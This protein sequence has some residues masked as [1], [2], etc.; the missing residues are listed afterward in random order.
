MKFV[1]ALL[2]RSRTTLSLLAI[3]VFT[4][5]YSYK[6]MPV[7]VTPNIAT[8][9]ISILIVLD[10]VSPEDGVRL[11]IRPSENQLRNIDGVKE[12]TARALE[13]YVNLVL[14]FDSSVDPAVA[15]N[16]VRAAMQRVRGDLPD[17]AK[18]PVVRELTSAEFPTVVVSL[19]GENV[20]ERTLYSTAQY[21][22]RRIEALPNVLEARLV[23]HRE[24]VVEAIINREQLETYK[25]TSGELLQAVSSNNVLIPAGELDT[26]KG[27]FSIKLPGLIETYQDVFNLPI[28]ATTEGVVKLGDLAQ[29][30]RTFKDSH[31]ITR[32]DGQPAISIEVNQRNGANMIEVANSVRQ[33]IQ[34]ESA[35][36]PAGVNAVF[37]FDQTPFALGMV[38]ELEGNIIAALLLVMVVIVAALG[39]RSGILVSIGVP[40]SMLIAM[41]VLD[42][43]DYSFN[44]M[45]LFGFLLSLGMVVDGAIVITEYADCRMADGCSSREAYAASVSR[46]FW[47]AAASIATTLGAF[48][49]LMFWQGTDG[50]FMRILPTTVFATLA[51][52]LLFALVFGPVLGGIF[53]KSTMDPETIHYLRVLEHEDPRQL[54]GVT[55]AYARMIERVH[56][57]PLLSVGISILGIVTIVMLY[58]KFNA[59]SMHFT[60]SEHN[61]GTVDVSARGNLSAEESAALVLEVEKIVRDTKNVKSVYTAAY[62]VGTAQGRR[63]AAEDEIGHMLV[64]LVDSEIRGVSSDEIFWDIRERTKH[65]PGIRVRAEGLKGGPPEGKDIQLQMTSDNLQK[66]HETAR[67]VRA[68]VD[69]MSQLIDVDDTLPLPGVEW[70][71]Q[72]DRTQAA[73]YGASVI[74]AGL[75]VQ[76]ITDGVK[77][78]EYR[79]D[80]AEE[81][82]EIRVRYPLPERSVEA[83]DMLTVN[84]LQGAVPISNFVQR[85]AKPR[86]NKLMRI[87]GMHVATVFANTE[88][89]VLPNDKIRELKQ[90]LDSEAN[91]DPEIT[92][93][94]RGANEE[95]DKSAQFLARAFMLSMLLIGAILVAQFN[96]FYQALLI[97]SAVLVSTVGV[98]LG[99]M[100]FRQPFSVV[101]SGLG[102]VALAGIVVNNNIILIDTFNVLRRQFPALSMTELSIR[103]GAQRL[104]PVFLTTITTG[105]GLIPLAIGL[106]VDV[107][108]RYATTHGMVAS[109]WKPLASTLVYGLVFST[110]LTL[111]ITPLLMVLPY[112]LRDWWQARSQA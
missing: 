107:F 25:I 68:H 59:G 6:N 43:L 70:E 86:I 7:E 76:M 97:L 93:S 90:W 53:G 37:T 57:K 102:V 94:F 65:L 81:E 112:R 88:P 61:Y 42:M 54:G 98:L 50:D 15:L 60:E 29:V 66:L 104:R 99:H 52:S 35:H 39:L 77:V 16:N 55:G 73:L 19:V 24:E 101:L 41:I 95:E 56:Q 45:V 20:Q 31:S 85:V 33:L 18:E 67:R 106:S 40:V 83:L 111:V 103:T 44:F 80:D 82:V 51:G 89:G 17:D 48:L 10:G 110:V 100:I 12:V 34:S 58:G 3:L 84:T 79:P 109:F 1:E 4:G 2:Q 71:M 36:I 62:P 14:E 49:P 64:Q 72:V 75:A 78:G 91:I 21:L 9:Y 13:G 11:L 108:G 30:H 96:S 47:P 69:G 63:G 46:M 22:R 38:S 87:D 32:V 5:F 8:S 105:L 26:G 92:L 28:K 74:D 27:R 23:G